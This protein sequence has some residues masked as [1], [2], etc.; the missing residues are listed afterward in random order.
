M[1]PNKK[2]LG[3]AF[4][5]DAKAVADA[6]EAL[7][8]EDALC[9]KS[10]LEAG[11]PGK[12][13][14]DGKAVEVTAAMVAVKRQQKRLAGRS[15]V[16]SVIEPSF[17]IGRILYCVFEHAYYTREGDDTRAVLRFTPLVA[18]VKATVFPLVQKEQ[19]N[20]L[21]AR[22][23]GAL[24]AAG[25]SNIIDTT[26]NTI[27]K[28]YART[29]E[30]GVPFAITVDFQALEEGTVTVRE[31]DSMAQVRTGVVFAG[32][33]IGRVDGL[34]KCAILF[35]SSA[36]THT[37][38]HTFIHTLTHKQQIRVPV[39]DIAGVIRSLVDATAAWADVA[40]KYPAVEAKAAADGEAAD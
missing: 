34:F 22:I 8:E 16:P 31:R 6:L 2:E 39:D 14:V 3:L 24:T 9:L 17:G 36:H 20:A 10:E 29:D 15:F 35:N 18:P 11:R 12:V 19:L 25:L 38:F 30:I 26:G 32:G 37:L 23:S 13:V 21:A 28:R 1:T 40:A 7:G 4:K 27:G 33:G 5:R